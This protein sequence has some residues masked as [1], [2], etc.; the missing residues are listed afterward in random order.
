[1]SG[2]AH[3]IFLAAAGMTGKRFGILVAS[4]LIATSTI[5]SA[6]LT[7]GGYGPLAGL[8]GTA[9][10]QTTQ[11][12]DA[13][14][15]AGPSPP[16]APKSA[17]KKAAPR[18][19]PA[20]QQAAPVPTSAPA[21]TPPTTTA[22]TPHKE[23]PSPTPPTA[24]LGRIKHVFVI[25]LSSP[26]YDRTWGANSQMPYLADTLRPKGELLS[27][28]SL[29]TNQGLPNYIAMVSGQ[30]PNKLTRANCP[31]YKEFPVGTEPNDYGLV[32]GAGCVYP[33]DAL[34]IGDQLNSGGL[35]WRG[36]M[37]DMADDN[38]PHSCVHPGTDE[39]DRPPVGGYAARLNPFIY[40]HS[41]LD[42]GA[43]AIN[44]IPLDG[45]PDGSVNG[46]DDDLKSAS[47]TPNLSF[48]SPN[49]C[50]DGIPNECAKGAP[51]GPASADGFLAKWV[52]RILDSPAYEQGGLVIITF[53]E[54]HPP[55][56]TD[57]PERVGTLLLSPYL[58]GGSGDGVGYGPY[59]ML[60]S[61][62]DLFSA[63]HLG[64]ANSTELPSFAP[65]LLGSGD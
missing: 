7:A 24:K 50:H 1:V 41:L 18:A 32:P 43:C 19:A 45:L 38:G 8:L 3:R 29:L 46:L 39:A 44:D 13:A 9:S 22:P 40:F 54:A 21:A 26:G 59:S 62:D 11:A 64:Y 34:T 47:T 17:A 51:D 60:R 25:T 20:A 58:P 30:G 6:A 5:I 35:T 61:I 63:A 56:G 31:K 16:P 28:Y 4:S 10:G 57:D 33:Q 65:A 14:A 49:L 12:A 52:S 37:E 53:G 15:S 55:D 2:V 36:Y 23:S 48:I 42:L 27:S